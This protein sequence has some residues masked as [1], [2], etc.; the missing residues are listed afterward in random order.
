MFEEKKKHTHN[1]LL[2]CYILYNIFNLIITR[3]RMIWKIESNI[4][5]KYSTVD[6]DIV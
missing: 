4:V 6:Y 5:G 3:R 1:T 2:L